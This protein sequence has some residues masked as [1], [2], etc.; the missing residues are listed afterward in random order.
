MPLLGPLP[1]ALQWGSFDRVRRHR[2]Q[3][4]NLKIRM[5]AASMH[6]EILEL[7]RASVRWGG[8]QGPLANTKTPAAYRT[9]YFQYMRS[10]PLSRPVS[11]D[12]WGG[13]AEIEVAALAF[14][15]P[16]HVLNA[17]SADAPKWQLLR[18]FDRSGSAGWVL[19]LEDNHYEPVFPPELSINPVW[20]RQRHAFF[21]SQTVI[22]AA[23][24]DP[25]APLPRARVVNKHLQDEAASHR[26][27]LL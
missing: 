13:A 11:M 1:F 23:R 5:N 3:A 20:A 2:D 18:V 6:P 21:T 19:L 14:Q 4:L 17:Y 7:Y 25:A 12:Y 9:T 27:R 8:A 26:K 24:W 22:D 15:V 10:L 16:I